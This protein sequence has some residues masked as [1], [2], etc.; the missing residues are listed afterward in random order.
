MATGGIR[1]TEKLI[2]LVAVCPLAVTVI[3]PVVAP[4][5]TDVVMLVAVLAVTD[6]AVP[7]NLTPLFAGVV[8]KFVPVIVIDVPTPPVVGV[9][10]VIVGAAVT[11]KLV[12][13]ATVWPTMI[14]V[15]VPEVAPVG[16]DVLIVVDVLPVMAAIVPL[17]FTVVFKGGELKFVPFIVTVDPTAPLVGLKLIIVC[18]KCGVP[19][20]VNGDVKLYAVVAPVPLYE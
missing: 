11:V 8:S 14:T 15:I 3:V 6:A 18:S 19:L 7:L 17:N 2:E 12:R 5:G 16:T 10:L 1:I 20:P 4:V 13:L 9:K